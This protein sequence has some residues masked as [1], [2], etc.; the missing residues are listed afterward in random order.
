MPSPERAVKRLNQTLRQ[1]GVELFAA[2]PET[3]GYGT[4]QERSL[5]NTLLRSL[6]GAG[7]GVRRPYARDL[8][9]E[10]VAT[11]E[12]VRPY[13]MTS[14]ASIAGLCESVEYLVRNELSGAVVECGVWRGGSVMA[15]ALT[16]LR[17]GAPDRD[18]Y[19]FDTFAGMTMPDERDQ[20]LTA[21]GQAPLERWRRD[22]R[23]EFNEWAYAPLAAVRANVLRTG[24]PSE[25]VHLIQ[26]PVEETVP[27]G[28][29]EQIALLRLDTDWYASTKH[30]LEHL[31]P[32]L[33]AG[34]V[35][36]LDDYGSWAGARQ[37][38][39]EYEPLSHAF[40]AR[41]DAFARIA[42]KPAR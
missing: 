15:I 41:L 18:L 31:Y 29:P 13:T 3:L 37:A 36:I 28:A 34:G 40:L 42:I 30:E 7:Y 35:L 12:A 22:D 23:G 21:P 1:F 5:R 27:A 14:Q 10:V 24:Y 20:S 11:I 33:A 16:L 17:L 25:R 38:A 6:A 4:T 8:S 9:S 26:G 2:A 39:D 19:L 32:R